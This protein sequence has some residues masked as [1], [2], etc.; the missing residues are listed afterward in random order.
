MKITNCTALTRGELGGD[1]SFSSFEEIRVSVSQ[2]TRGDLFIAFSPED[3]ELA[4]KKGAYGIMYDFD[5]TISD[6]EIA[7]IKVRNISTASMMIAK[8][9]LLKKRVDFVL[10][11]RIT[12]DIAQTAITDNRAAFITPNSIKEL[13]ST[14]KNAD[15]D[16]YI[17]FDEDYFSELTS[18]TIEKFFIQKEKD[19]LP[20]NETMFETQF[21]EADREVIVKLPSFMMKQ[22]RCIQKICTTFNLLH[23]LSLAK[24]KRFFDYIFVDDSFKI[25]EFGKTSKVLI[26]TEFESQSSLKEAIEFVKNKGRWGRLLFLLPSKLIGFECSDSVVIT[27]FGSNEELYDMLEGSD[28]NFALLVDAN[29][30]IVSKEKKE[31]H[32]LF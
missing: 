24:S 26:F 30:N 1:P 15:K 8:Y 29:K 23:D 5:Y 31:Q 13:F 12:F 14:I 16:I 6:N 9:L 22:I 28:F 11:D 20:I 17:G 27:Y 4:I 2:I 7:W 10:T 21:Y 32:S 19:N 3:V 25:R 18:E